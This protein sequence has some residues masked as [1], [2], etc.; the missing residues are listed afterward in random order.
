MTADLPWERLTG[1]PSGTGVCLSGGGLRAAAFATGVLQQL[2][3]D[4]GLLFGP[5]AADHL[6]VVSGGSYIAASAMLNAAT[7]D[8]AT[9]PI[10]DPSPEVSHI[11]NHARY[12]V[13][14]GKVLSVWPFAWRF[15]VSAIASALLFSWSGFILADIGIIIS[16][17]WPGLVLEDWFRWPVAAVAIAAAAV[18]G[19]SQLTDNVKL[20]Y[21]YASVGLPALA[22]SVPTLVAL[23]ANTVWLRSPMWW[24]THGIA[25]GILVLYV[26]ASVLPLLRPQTRPV[27]DSAVRFTLRSL[28]VLITC[29]VIAAMTPTLRRVFDDDGVPTAG[30]VLLVFVSLAGGAWASYVHDVASLHRPY[31]DAAARCFAVVRSAG[32]AQVVTPA[33]ATRLSG[34]A[35]PTDVNRRH[36]RLLVCATANVRRP[37]GRDAVP[38][39]FSHD[40]SGLSGVSGASF[41]T[42]QLELGRIRTRIVASTKEP[43]LSL[44]T[45]VAMTGAA[46][47]PVMGTMTNEGARPI[48]AALNLRLG[49]WLPN[50]LSPDRRRAVEMRPSRFPKGSPRRPEYGRLGPGFSAVLGEVLGAHSPNAK[51]IYVTDGGHYDNL[52][53]TTLLRARCKD[54]WCVDAYAGRKHLGRQMAAGIELAANELGVV[55]DI[56]TTRFDLVDGS[57]ELAPHSYA[58]G[59][60]TYPDTAST[61]TIVVLKSALTP[62]TPQPLRDY[63]SVDAK[64]PYHSTLI[65][66]Y[67]TERYDHYRRLGH[68]V[69]A[70]AIAALT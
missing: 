45:A 40:R 8:A 58:I 6:A 39:V 56:D 64:F 22:A 46:A 38:F 20:Q 55:I 28:M 53:L 68:H 36:P 69:T 12:L 13:D 61:G 50:P 14:R 41:S 35:P 25:P 65:Q 59:T 26:I 16:Y 57:D 54:I 27:A 51:R 18:L 15:V 44:M 4:K 1:D 33:T 67:G 29:F 48:M 47:S 2:Q 17:R 30:D 66:W 21:L 43:E 9:P 7:A 5:Q 62:N 42:A 10:A 32:G 70:E 11:V 37:T 24:L 49:V 52:G 63:R 23:V 60:I 19:V 31:R 34:L 3:K